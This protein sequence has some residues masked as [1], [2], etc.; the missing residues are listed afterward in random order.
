L[1]TI[2]IGNRVNGSLR[3]FNR[4]RRFFRIWCRFRSRFFNWNRDWRLY[5]LRR[6][7]LR[8]WYRF[9][10][11]GFNRV[12]SRPRSHWNTWLR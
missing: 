6:L 5:G 10:C 1:W 2:R 3:F 9:Y 4:N 7:R 12:R 8:N 11:R